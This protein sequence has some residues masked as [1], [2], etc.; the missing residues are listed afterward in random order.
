MDVNNK[1]VHEWNLDQTTLPHNVAQMPAKQIYRL[2]LFWEEQHIMTP[3]L[4][5]FVKFKKTSVTEKHKYRCAQKVST[6][7][8]TNEPTV[9]LCEQISLLCGI[10]RNLGGLSKIAPC[11]A[12]PYMSLIISY[13]WAVECHCKAKRVGSDDMLMNKEGKFS[14]C[15]HFCQFC[16]CVDLVFFFQKHLL[17][18]I[19]TVFC[20]SDTQQVV[21][22]G[23]DI[24][25]VSHWAQQNMSSTLITLLF[26]TGA[27]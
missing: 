1:A 11:H 25:A 9:K 7:S 3:Q 10:V 8:F 13:G 15:F 19:L 26:W 14:F 16:D 18:Q 21:W 2:I 5:G 6:E 4:K 17:V 20:L 27:K 12:M 22:L 23:G 24:M